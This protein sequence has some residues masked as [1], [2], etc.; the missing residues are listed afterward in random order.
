MEATKSRRKPSKRKP[1]TDLTNAAPSSLPSSI[2]PPT[3][4]SHSLSLKS[5]FN[6]NPNA[7]LNSNSNF[8]ATGSPIN[9]N[10]NSKKNKEDTVK[11]PSNEANPSSTLS[12]PPKTPSVSGDGDSVL[13]E[14]STVYKRRQTAEKGRPKGRGLWNL[15]VALLK[16]ECQT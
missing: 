5:L 6:D 15:P 8:T 4:S 9:D 2:K 13:S 3:K 14:L 10:V 1:F 11:G 7:H 12:P 16:Q